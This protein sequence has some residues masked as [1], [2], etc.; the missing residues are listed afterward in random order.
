MQTYI[1]NFLDYL[2]AE[3]GLSSNTIG[4]YRSDL[5]HF[6]KYLSKR[7]VNDVT[8]IKQAHVSG[9]VQREMERG[10]GARS[11]ARALVAVKMFLAFL[12]FEGVTKSNAAAVVETPSTWKKVPAVLSREE[13]IFVIEAADGEKDIEIR[14]RAILEVMYAAGLR[15]TE[16]ATLKKDDFN[17]QY[18]YLRCRGK[19]LKERVVPAGRPACKAV[20]KFLSGPRDHLLK[21]REN[22]VLFVSRRGG[23][24]SR[25]TIWRIIRKY[26]LKA[27]MSRRIYPHIFRHSFATHLLE[28]GA[29]LRSVQE[30]LGHADISTTQIYTHVDRKRLKDIHRK[31]H[32]RP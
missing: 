20:E 24:L 5:S 12:T 25:Q 21:E 6:C 26:A 18:G 10:L 22:D 15:A 16:A 9:F 7:R 31:Y 11:T 3:R 17:M 30:M 13:I 32:P 8:G 27:G 14:D 28:G 19:G 23:A 29:N 2:S 4:S 1:D